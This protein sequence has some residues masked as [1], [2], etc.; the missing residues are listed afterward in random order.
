[1]YQAKEGMGMVV[2]AEIKGGF[3]CGIE[4]HQHKF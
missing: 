4:S 2:P 1:M 3:G